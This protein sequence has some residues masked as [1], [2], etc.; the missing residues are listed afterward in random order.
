MNYLIY[1]SFVV[2]FEVEVGILVYKVL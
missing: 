1:I 2:G